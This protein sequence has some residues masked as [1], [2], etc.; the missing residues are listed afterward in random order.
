[1]SSIQ[2]LSHSLPGRSVMSR[3]RASSNP[4]AVYRRNKKLSQEEVAQRVS[5]ITGEELGQAAI[6][7]WEL[8]KVDLKKVHP[9]RLEAY[10]KVLGIRRT[11]LAQAAGYESDDLFPTSSSLEALDEDDGLVGMDYVVPKHAAPPARTVD[12]PEGLLEAAEIWGNRSGNELLNHPK[13]QQMLAQGMSFGQGPETPDEW[14]DYFR[15]VKK[16]IRVD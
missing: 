12:I 7:Y 15:S 4:L 6:S 5:E 2:V 14:Y 10:A 1:M 13:V 8:G 11:E 16:Y 9:R 3:G